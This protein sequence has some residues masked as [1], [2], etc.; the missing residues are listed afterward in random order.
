MSGFDKDWLAL[1]EPA[2]RAARAKP[3]V[4]A[5]RRHLRQERAP[6]IIDIGC[7]TGSTWRSLSP[8]FP[9]QTRWRLL[10]HDPLLLAEAAR[11][12]GATGTVSLHEFDLNQ[13]ESLA[14][15]GVS[16]VTAS[17]LFD[18]CSDAF[19]ARFAR[20]LAARG[21]GLYAALNYDGRMEWS[22]AH[23]LDRQVVED[24]NRH[25]RID[26]GLGPALGPEATAHLVRQFEALGYRTE[27]ASSPWELGPDEAA[28]Q[29]ALLKGLEQPLGEIGSLTSGDIRT[30]LDFR[31]A[32]VR[33][34]GSRYVVGHADFL[35]LPGALPDTL[36]RE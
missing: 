27:V 9:A 11:R 22:I 25:Q 6:M 2:D 4:E 31:L 5:L 35:A 18:L 3:M 21:V 36:P 30:W 8:D 20:L 15:D 24:F 13:A 1:R 12:I 19:C 23:P 28:L 32:A 29:A 34:A 14:L 26:K 17:A 33:K 16:M 7:G 10:D